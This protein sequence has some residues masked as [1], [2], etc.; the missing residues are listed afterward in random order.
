M[1]TPSALG[2][3]RI[4][5]FDYV[6]CRVPEWRVRWDEPSDLGS[7]PEIPDNAQWKLFPTD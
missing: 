4:E 5:H 1:G 6:P 7:P 3:V 2:G